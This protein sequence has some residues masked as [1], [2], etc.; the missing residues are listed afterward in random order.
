MAELMI[1]SC[2]LEPRANLVSELECLCR[3]ELPHTLSK[4]ATAHIFELEIGEARYGYYRI[5]ADDVRMRW[6]ADPGLDF[7]GKCFL[8]SLVPKD[9]FLVCL[10]RIFIA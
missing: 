10:E 6:K 4:T 3:I 2:K 8:S 1:S 7:I 5:C 9:R